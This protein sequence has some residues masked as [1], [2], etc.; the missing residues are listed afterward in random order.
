MKKLITGLFVFSIWV[1]AQAG[2]ESTAQ[3]LLQDYQQ[4]G[5]MQADAARGK[6]IWHSTNEKRSCSSCHSNQLN[7]TGKHQ[8]TGKPI[9]PMALSVNKARY[10]DRKKIEKWFFATESVV[11]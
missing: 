10:Q 1:N 2:L 11:I 5:A 3:K 8:K 9:K 7:N 4:Q 6:S